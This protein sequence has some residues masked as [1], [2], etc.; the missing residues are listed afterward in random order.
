MT[1]AR[2]AARSA[3]YH[4]RTNLAV[5]FGVSAAV[6]VLGGALLVGDSV[7]ASLR[8]I[9]LGR[10]GKTD[11]V[12]SSASFF[13]DAVAGRIRESLGTAAVP[14]IVAS[15][16]VTH[17]GSGRRAANVTVYGVDERF[18]LFHGSAPPAGVATSP[19]LAAELGASS[20]DTLLVRLQRASEIPIDSLF[21][22]KDDIGRTVRLTLG[23]VLPRER[24][25][26]FSLRPQQADM[27]A[28][29]APVQRIQR[30][31]DADRKVNTILI[32]GAEAAKVSEVARSAFTPQDLGLNIR[33][34]GDGHSVI[35]DATTGI[36]SETIDA[37]VQAAGKKLGYAP[38]PVFTYLANVMR[39]RD[40]TIPY[41]LVTA[42][43]PG[44]VMPAQTTPSASRDG[45]IL[46]TWAAREL[47]AT[48]GDQVEIEYY[49][50]DANAGLTTHRHTF[51][52]SAVVA[53]AGLAGDRQL[54]PEYPG[55]SGAASLADWDPP[56]PVD[57]SLVRPA[58]E[59]YWDDYRATP[60][61]FIPYTDG[62]KLWQTRYGA[63]TSIRFPVPSGTAPD[64]IVRR[65]TDALRSSLRPELFGV[66]VLPVR[67]QAL[68][69][70]HGATDFGE[71]FTYFSF[72]LMVSALLL[73]VLFFRLGV[74][75]RLRQIGVL[76]AAGFAIAKVRTL[77]L[78]EA[79]VLSALGA[80]VG[81]AA[82]IAYAYLIVYGLRTWWIGAV[83]TPQ[84]TLHVSVAPIA[85]GALAGIIAAAVCVVLSLRSV[86][87]L[88]PRA[89]LTAQTI[90]DEAVGNIQ[91]RRRNR[92]LAIVFA[93]LAAAAAAAGFASIQAQAGAF[94][95]AGASALI[96]ALF[97]FA[98]ALRSRPRGLISGHGTKPIARLGLRSAATR[99]TRSVLS[100]ALI[101]SAAFIIVSVDAFRKGTEDA[102]G[103]RVSGT[104]GYSLV[105][106][107]EIPIVHSLNEPSGREAMS[108]QSA[109]FER[110]RF[111]RFRVRPGDDASCLNLYRP[112]N[113]R[114]IAPEASF[115]AER[116]FTLSSSLAQ[117]DAERQN[118]WLL[119][120]RD[121]GNGPIPVIADATSLQYVLHAK[122]GD[123][124]SM[125]IGAERPLALQYVAAIT[126]SVLQGELIMSEENF[127]RLFPS[128]QGYKFFLLDDPSVHSRQ[129]ASR[130][131]GVIEKELTPFG[132]DAVPAAERLEAFHRVENTYLSTFQ[133]LGGLGL[134][135]G[136]I[137]LAAVMFRNVLERRRELALLRAVGYD[138]R[139]VRQVILAEALLLLGTGL[140]AGVFS[141]ALAVFPAWIGRGGARPGAGLLV[142]VGAV[143]VAGVVSSALAARAALRGDVLHAL[144]AE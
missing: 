81:G 143:A 127:V 70:S 50:W 140:A 73:A 116:R 54:A 114:I 134:L 58:D 44:E 107:S 88:T 125:D 126:D 110:V 14:L 66:A 20:G 136:T 23:D 77:L 27:R 98:A 85:I 141:A 129:D 56:F 36:L 18:W 2:L 37:A 91:R 10:L 19:A 144:R 59:K 7:R 92:I 43:D 21:S 26:E 95:G 60:K 117:S 46:N 32:S 121:V 3:T 17:E 131:A 6:A 38:V 75:Q 112:T 45:M 48:T 65:L 76:R 72:F 69:A 52:V 122:V 139:R 113:P 64:E 29:F 11:V 111:T 35:V 102:I 25:G 137:G 15:G 78:I 133:S 124:F 105:A 100:A 80:L 40:K 142:L 93:V 47:H 130:L 74:E 16:L 68:A 101:A 49:L 9:A 55:V 51:P 63:A 13:S 67:A 41:S 4:W 97:F 24:L 94:F 115:I 53:I 103:D 62:R 8:D 31:L 42:I 120:T 132:F 22:H 82:A 33:S 99:P 5:L 123:V 30:D 96:A 135:L 128:Q 119:L 39:L 79:F 109:D 138:R 87:K 83:G 106:T 84:L 12:I 34:S 61:A 86:G 118:P 108:L 1:L 28:V 90:A 104:G 71:Y 89:L 57:L